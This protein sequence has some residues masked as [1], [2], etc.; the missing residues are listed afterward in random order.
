MK[1][2]YI[3]GRAG[4][5]ILF[6]T[7]T[8][9]YTVV[10]MTKNMFSSAMAV[11]VEDGVMTKAQT[12]AIGAAFW[13]VYG[14]F[15]LLGGVISD[16]LPPSLLICI[17]IAGGALANF[18]IYLNHSYAVIMIA[19]MLNAV[20]QSGV[21]PAVFRIV[22]IEIEPKYRAKAMFLI[23]YTSTLGLVASMLVA[24]LVEKWDE[25]FLLSGIFLIAVL[26]AWILI[27]TPISRRMTAEQRDEAVREISVGKS[28]HSFVGIALLSGLFGIFIINFLKTCVGNGIQMV[29]PTMLM[30]SYEGLPAA[31]STRLGIILVIAATFG[32]PLASFVDKHITGNEMK[33]TLI[34]SAVCAVPVA[35]NC[36]VGAIPYPF[37]IALLSVELLLFQAMS[38]F[39]VVT[40]A[41]RFAYCGKSGAAAGFL[42]ASG[43]FANVVASFA[44]PAVAQYFSWRVVTVIWLAL[45]L[46]TLLVAVIFS[47]RWTHF[48][49]KDPDY[50]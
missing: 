13:L 1:N 42:N 7:V 39:T 20:V 3:S 35:L 37:V 2:R 29:T 46:L 40:A 15:Q 21:W 44:F 28:E 30:E 14:A 4:N 34:L 6:L 47:K 19:W 41:R 32:N 8:V 24:S 12:G 38:I 27:Y 31:V 10:Y 48:V 25:N 33:A 26:V 43:A 5:I 22:S 17:G 23:L 36:F 45:M 11:I 9:M 50:M 16:K 18:V 49:E